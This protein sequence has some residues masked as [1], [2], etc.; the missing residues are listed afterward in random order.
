MELYGLSTGY[1]P[2]MRVNLAKFHLMGCDGFTITVEDQKPRAGRPLIDRPDEHLGGLHG[3]LKSN[4]PPGGVLGR[5]S[6]KE[7]TQRSMHLWGI[8]KR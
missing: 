6:T 4:W 8:N 1:L 7:G 5:L 3:F 2:W